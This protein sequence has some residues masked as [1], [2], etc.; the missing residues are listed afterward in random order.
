MEESKLNGRWNVGGVWY[1]FHLFVRDQKYKWKY[2]GNDVEVVYKI[3]FML[4]F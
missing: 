1:F 4:S 2:F 3:V